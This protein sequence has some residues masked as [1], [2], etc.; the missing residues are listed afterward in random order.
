MLTLAGSVSGFFFADNVIFA[1]LAQVPMV[2]YLALLSLSYRTVPG[3]LLGLTAVLVIASVG[4][5]EWTAARR[6]GDFTVLCWNLGV[7]VPHLEEAAAGLSALDWDLALLQEVG[8]TSTHDVGQE[9]LERMPVRY[10][11]RGGYEGELLILSRAHR[12]RNERQF[13]AAGLREELTAEVE[14]DGYT[15][16]VANVHFV[17]TD[18]RQPTGLLES[19]ELRQRQVRDL[20]AQ[21]DFHLI[22]G[23]FNLPPNVDPVNLMGERYQD[24]FQTAGW[25][26]GMT[27][28]RPLPLWR[29]DYLFAARKLEVCKFQTTSLGASDHRAILTQLNLKQ[30]PPPDRL[31]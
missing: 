12:L 14:L 10:A 2:G 8:L 23:D 20:L 5:P 19:A 24:C 22:G 3:M 16:R 31:R 6:S 25:G 21:G 11:V 9:L 1:L 28:P 13:L 27:Y 18:Y 17:R 30:A 7:D 15:L 4:R 29:I 26:L